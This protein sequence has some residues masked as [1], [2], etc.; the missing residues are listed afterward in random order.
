ME[1]REG[2]VT[3]TSGELSETV[4][5]SQQGTPINVIHVATTG[6]LASILAGMGE[7]AYW[8][9]ALKITG[10][11]NA[12][13]F[14]T[15]SQLTALSDLDLSEVAITE[16][17][18]KAF[19]KSKNV[20]NL[21]LPKTLTTIGNEMFYYSDLRSVVIPNGVTTIGNDAFNHSLLT[22]IEIPASVETIESQAFIWCFKLA[23]VTFEKGSRLKTLVGNT[24]ADCSSIT[25]IE[26]PAGVETIGGQAFA[27]TSITSIKIPASVETLGTCAFSCC[28]ELVTVTFEKG[29]K[30]K[31]LN[32]G[33]F[34]ECPITS[35]ELPASVETISNGV[36]WKCSE[37]TTITFEKNSRLK[38]IED[39]SID[40]GAFGN[41]PNLT[42]LDMA[43]CKQIQYF[44]AYALCK[45]EH[46]GLFKIGT[47]IPPK[48]S[49][50]NV[51]FGVKRDILK[52]PRGYVVDYYSADGWRGKFYPI[53]ELDD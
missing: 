2:T 12:E 11:L 5:I 34:C 13:D 47:A 21:I 23:T 27:G 24:F 14:V 32:Y 20:Q 4:T 7:D 28:S 52:V 42:T 6:T 40:T 19:Y 41:L 48:C 16:L 45:D 9:T 35:I 18:E 8:V 15:I 30:V 26:I 43:E 31:T 1:K 17:P 51:F 50:N 44:G 39:G 33:T 46:L 22:S 53:Q 10:M 29:S 49:L 38:T 37:L 25:S 36:F 3:I